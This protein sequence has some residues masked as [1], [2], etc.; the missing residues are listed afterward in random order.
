MMII[1]ITTVMVMQLILF[2]TF[3]AAQSEQYNQSMN[4]IQ[5]DLE[6]VRYQAREYEKNATPF[7]TRCAATTPD[8]GLAAGFLNDASVGLGGTPK[9][10]GPK[11]LGGENLL[12]NR[13]AAYTTSAQ[14]FKLLQL[15]YTVTPQAGGSAIA[16]LETEVVINAAFKCP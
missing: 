8:N 3:L 6:S 1:T 7:S 13:I 10:L 4:W 16:S 9:V 14:P 2:A 11:F 12:L 15:R 5:A